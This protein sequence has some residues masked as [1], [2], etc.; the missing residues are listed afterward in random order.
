[1]KMRQLLQHWQS[2]SRSPE[3]RAALSVE[4]TLHDI[5]RLHALADMYP[6]CQVNDIL[7]DLL[8]AALDDLQEAFPY[9]HGPRQVGEDELGNPLYEDIGPTPRFLALT[10]H[11][12]A[13][14]QTPPRTVP[15]VTPTRL[16]S[17]PSRR[18]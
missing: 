15:S 13:A 18:S 3:P 9:V 4:L 5:A 8:R 10:R 16:L 2:L 11:H 17:C 6:G 1:M 7:A 14:L 12:L